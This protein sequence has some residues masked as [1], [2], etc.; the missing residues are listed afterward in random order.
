[1]FQPFNQADSSTSRRY[2]GSGLGLAIVWRLVALMG[3]E[4]AVESTLGTGS[5]FSFTAR[6]GRAPASA[7]QPRPL[8]DLSRMRIL[9]ADESRIRAEMLCMLL[10]QRGASIT[11]TNSGSRFLELIQ[12]D[13]TAFDAIIAD[14]A[15]STSDGRQVLAQIAGKTSAH[16]RL[17]VTISADNLS[18]ET[19]RL[20]LLGLSRYIVKPVKRGE[21]LAAIAAMTGSH[22]DSDSAAASHSRERKIAHLISPPRAVRRLRILFAD[23]S[24][25]NRALIKAYLKSTPHEIEFAENGQQAI[26]RVLTSRY[27]LTFMDIQMPIVDGYAA[28]REIRDWEKRSGRASMPIIALTASADADA[29]RRTI[30]AGCNL[31]V[32][33]P[34]KKHI[35][36]ETIGRYAPQSKRKFAAADRKAVA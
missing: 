9:V 12:L 24:P 15:I 8:P 36:L 20:E 4:T 25:D 11:V 23:D 19:N 5:V 6:F 28:V 17:I 16:A 30:E 31:H 10:T 1:L 3:G 27:D 32:S 7:A 34:L 33:K 14:S 2:G 21:L 13:D 22:N 29:V 35:L 18:G 26:S